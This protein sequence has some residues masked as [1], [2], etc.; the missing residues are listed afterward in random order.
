MSDA[1]EIYQHLLDRGVSEEE[2]KSEIHKKEK[3]YGG[4]ITK[5]GALFLIAKEHGI[6]VRSNK[7][8]KEVYESYEEEI[9]YNEFTINITDVQENMTNIVLLG[10]VSHIFPCNEFTR[11]DGTL[12]IVGSFLLTDMTDTIKIVLWGEQTKIMKTEFFG[13]G[14]ILRVLNGYAKIGINDKLEIHL[15]KKSRIILKPDDISNKTLKALEALTLESDAIESFQNKSQRSGHPQNIKAVLNH[16]GFINTVSGYVKLRDLKEFK[17]DNGDPSFLLK[18]ILSDESGAIK[19]NVWDWQAIEV[20]KLLE[21]GILVRL[22]KVYV[23]N[24]DFS[25]DKELQFTKK[26]LIEFI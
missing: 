7:I 5:E 21:D 3:K 8:D 9:D 15:S 4:F 19:V 22:H 20:L 16:E 1:Q 6:Q 11:K 17:K 18:F 26:S 10:K 24:N 25:G 23:R 2:L 14:I 13:L 12:G